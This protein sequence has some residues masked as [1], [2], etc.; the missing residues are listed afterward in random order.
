MF[1]ESCFFNCFR[2]ASLMYIILFSWILLIWNIYCEHFF[3][4]AVLITNCV[5]T[6]QGLKSKFSTWW[7]FPC[8][9]NSENKDVIIIHIFMRNISCISTTHHQFLNLRI[10]FLVSI[11]RKN[12][13]YVEMSLKISSKEY[14][15][16]ELRE[17]VYMSY[18]ILKL[19][20]ERFWK[21]IQII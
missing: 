18:L 17:E 5:F 14:Q 2:D 19:P 16:V 12:L 9:L 11:V 7:T 20:I 21:W 13:E 4:S 3:L 6:Y 1:L 8:G 10:E 15:S